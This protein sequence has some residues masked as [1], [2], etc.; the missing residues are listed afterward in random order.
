MNK[1]EI[2]Q[3]GV[4]KVSE[5]VAA[6]QNLIAEMRAGN[7]ETKSSMG[8]KYETGREMLQQEINTLEVQLNAHLKNLNIIQ[9]GSDELHTTIGPSSLVQTSHGFFYFSVALG[10]LDYDG[11]Q[12]IFLSPEAPLAK[13]LSS[14]K[15]GDTVTFNGTDHFIHHIW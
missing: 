8:D 11:I 1:A 13:A 7:T 15:T 14:K 3:L 9:N 4:E 12:I 6:L 10:P 5:K 2:R